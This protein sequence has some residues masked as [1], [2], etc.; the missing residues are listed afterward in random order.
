MSPDE[1][2]N[3]F[4]SLPEDADKLAFLGEVV[5]ANLSNRYYLEALLDKFDLNRVPE[6]LVLAPLVVMTSVREHLRDAFKRF[7]SRAS[8]RLID[9]EWDPRDAD[10]VVGELVYW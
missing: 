3:K 6:D 9:L 1:A 10:N 8:E 7:G 5:T 2:L 4:Y